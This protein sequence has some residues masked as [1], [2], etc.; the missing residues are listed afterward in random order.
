M[1]LDVGSALP[2]AGIAACS[3]YPHQGWQPTSPCPPVLLTHGR[4]DPV[5]PFM[6]SEE[7]QKQLQASG[8]TARLVP[9]EGGHGIDESVLP[10]LK[11]FIAEHIEG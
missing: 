8:Q 6:A 10:E 7:M 1:A 5:V 9:F 11:R 2:L 3:G 4:Q